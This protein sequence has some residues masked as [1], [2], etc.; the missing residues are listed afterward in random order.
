VDYL[1]LDPV[2]P[3]WREL[4]TYSLTKLRADLTAGAMVAIVTIPQA[5]GFALVV[6]IPVSAVIATAIIGTVVCALFSG[7]RHL[8][9]GPTN[10]I[11]IILAGALL[12][13]KDVPLTSLQKVLVIGFLIGIFQISAGFFKLGGL[14]HFVSRTVIVAYGLAVAI[15]IGVGQWGNL[16]GI[17]TAEDVSLPGTLRHI[18]FSLATFTLNPMTAGLGVASLLGMI[19]IRRLRPNWPDGLIVITAV[20]FFGH[21]LK[22]AD[23][24][25]PLVRDGGEVARSMPLFVGFPGNAE[26]LSLVPVLTSVALAAAILGMLDV[27]LGGWIGYLIAGFIGACLLIALGRAFRGQSARPPI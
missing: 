27:V 26:G 8:V 10:T 18:F 11:S 17:G 23:S 6:G 9:F 25:V 12:S 15:L 16:L 20:T 21:L 19:L 4:Q 24:G 7:S 14:T 13:V 3:V 5:I 2:P 22:V 1:R